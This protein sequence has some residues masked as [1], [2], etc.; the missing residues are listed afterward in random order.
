MI[1]AIDFFCG[2]G[3]LTRGLLDA[4]ISVVAGIDN[5]NRIRKTY[6]SNNRPSR[7]IAADVKDVNIGVLREELGISPK[8]PTLYAACTP[9][10]PFSTLNAMRAARRKE[11]ACCLTSPRSSIK[12]RRTSSLSKTCPAWEVPLEKRFTRNSRKS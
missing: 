9:C 6:E 11:I 2:A 3:G 1:K 5:D 10:Q 7:F 12:R 8:D 4:G